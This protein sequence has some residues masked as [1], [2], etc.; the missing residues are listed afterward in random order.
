MREIHQP[1]NAEEEPNAEGRER[2]KA[3]EA[4]RVEKVLKKPDHAGSP[5]LA[6][7]RAKPK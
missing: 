1:Q 7:G 3:A 6:A 2:I 5:A 4:K